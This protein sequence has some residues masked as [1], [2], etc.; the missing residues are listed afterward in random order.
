[1][2]LLLV[3]LFVPFAFCQENGNSIKAAVEKAAEEALIK[4]SEEFDRKLAVLEKKN[5]EFLAENNKKLARFEERFE[6]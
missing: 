4:N 2:I 1:M 3:S 6:K 5:E